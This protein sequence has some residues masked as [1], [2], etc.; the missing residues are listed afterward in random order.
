MQRIKSIAENMN[1]REINREIKKILLDIDKNYRKIIENTGEVVYLEAR[2]QHP[3]IFKDYSLYNGKVILEEI[4]SLR[5]ENIN[6]FRKNKKEFETKLYEELYILDLQSFMFLQIIL[7]FIEFAYKSDSKRY[8]ALHIMYI[9]ISI[10][11]RDLISMRKCLEMGLNYQANLIFRNYIELS[12]IGLA[13]MIDDNFVN[14]YT[15]EVGSEKQEIIKRNKFRAINVH[16]FI[17]DE[18]KLIKELSSFIEVIDEIRNSLYKKTSQ[19]THGN[20]FRLIN[21]CFPIKLTQKEE[22]PTLDFTGNISDEIEKTIH[23]IILYTKCFIQSLFVFTVR[24]KKLPFKNFGK[25]GESLIY[26]NEITNRL[27][28]ECFKNIKL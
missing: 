5:K 12:E 13:C 27:I 15:R 21:E 10:L 6:L 1:K 26:S 11:Y 24:N 3:N 19:F 8:K 7:C 2:F 14:E 25:D 28:S 18:F 22:E 4:D 23:E 9:L 20:P 17:I 16:K